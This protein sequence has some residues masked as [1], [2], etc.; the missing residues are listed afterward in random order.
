MGVDSKV[1]VVARQDLTAEVGRA[2]LNALNIWQRN[3]LDN[4]A[5]EAGYDNRAQFMFSSDN[6]NANGQKLWTNGVR[7]QANTFDCFQF[8]FTDEGDNRILWYFTDCSCDTNDITKEHTLMFHIGCWGRY[9]II[10]DQVS[11]ALE[12]FGPV[13]W[14]HNDCDAE[15]YVLQN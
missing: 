4:Y 10:M 14:D 15:G 7:L 3:R 2:V 8:V 12:P 5:R 6:E 11:K 1:F 9:E 13:Y